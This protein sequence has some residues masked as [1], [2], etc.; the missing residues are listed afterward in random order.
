MEK[1]IIINKKAPK[2]IGPYSLAVRLD[3][4]LFIS[5][6]IGL[7]P[8]TN[9]LVEGGIEKQTRQIFINL[10]II[11]EDLDISFSNIVKVTIFIKDITNFE[12]VNNIYKEYFLKTFPARS[13]V[14]VSAIPKNAEIEIE[15]IAY[16]KNQ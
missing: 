14:E 9:R 11:L 1:E 10:G 7:D 3:N 4:F 2:V 16:I 6:Q 5:G 8:L 12:K 15:A 13:C